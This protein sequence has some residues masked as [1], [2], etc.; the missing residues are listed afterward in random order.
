MK[1]ASKEG[2]QHLEKAALQRIARQRGSEILKELKS[3][4]VGAG[5]RSGQHGTPFS[6]AGAQ[7]IR[8]GNMVKGELVE[9]MKAAGRRLIG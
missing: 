4:G 9:A 7:L 6:Q 5:A 1:L 8:E 2:V 3:G